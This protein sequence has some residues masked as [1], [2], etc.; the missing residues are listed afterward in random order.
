MATALRSSRSKIEIRTTPS[1]KQMIERAAE[2]EGV[3]VTSFIFSRVLPEAERV[4]GD[5]S[6][7]ILTTAQWTKLER[8]LNRPS[9]HTPKLRKLMST[10][11][12]LERRKRSRG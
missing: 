3:N 4:L 12:V 6:L 5:Q 11:S 9:R 8:L 7:F 10:P 2:V 1:Q